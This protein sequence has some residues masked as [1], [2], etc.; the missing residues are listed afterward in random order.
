MLLPH[1]LSL[2]LLLLLEFLSLFFVLEGVLALF[3]MRD[4]VFFDCFGILVNSLPLLAIQLSS[5]LKQLCLVFE[6]VSQQLDRSLL[7]SSSDD[8]FCS[9]RV[10]FK[11][12]LL[13]VLVF[14]ASRELLVLDH[15]WRWLVLVQQ[16]FVF[17]HSCRYIWSLKL[18]H[19]VSMWL[20]LCHW[21]R[22]T[23]NNWLISGILI[24]VC[25]QE[26]ELLVARD[27][28]LRVVVIV[29][30]V[31]EGRLSIVLSLWTF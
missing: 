23:W 30:F 11:G 13:A 12:Q 22:V 25:F 21:C 28:L 14:E 24:F 26:G 27:Q 16:S 10:W 3:H 2:S 5:T 29:A 31:F 9:F 19:R 6:Q 8:C 18:R 7:Y 1:A 15:Y 17:L 20:A 4:V